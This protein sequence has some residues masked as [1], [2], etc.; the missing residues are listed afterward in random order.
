MCYPLP[1][2]TKASWI[3]DFYAVLGLAGAHITDP[4]GPVDPGSAEAAPLGTV[5]I[6]M[7][8]IAD[9]DDPVG[10][11]AGLLKGIL[12]DARVGLIGLCIFA[13]HDVVE[14]QAQVVEGDFEVLAID[15]ADEAD[16]HRPGGQGVAH[17]REQGWLSPVLLEAENMGLRVRQDVMVREGA[18]ETAAFAFKKRAEGVIV[19]LF[20]F[21]EKAFPP[22]DRQI[23]GAAGQIVRGNDLAADCFDRLAIAANH[24]AVKVQE[25]PVQTA[26]HRV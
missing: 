25:D 13:G 9:V 1:P 23:A 4:A 7:E 11:P 20:D 6:A 12:E 24:R 21:G 3:Q 16:G 14:G 5:D 15:V 26:V 22:I 18:A 8:A 19:G 2:I 17:I 10:A